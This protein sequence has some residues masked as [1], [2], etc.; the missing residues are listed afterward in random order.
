MPGD[1]SAAPDRNLE[2]NL[3]A[4]AGRDSS[5]AERLRDAREIASGGTLDVRLEEGGRWVIVRRTGGAEQ[6]LTASDQL[7]RNAGRVAEQMAATRLGVFLLLD[8]GLECTR[9]ILAREPTQENE[10]PVPVYL[11][12]P[13]AA[14][15]RAHLQ[16]A[17]LADALEDER[18][19]PFSGPEA[20]G[21]FAKR[22][23][24]RAD[25]P[26]PNRFILHGNLPPEARTG[27]RR[28]IE[29]LDAER[30]RE[31]E[32]LRAELDAYWASEPWREAFA[33]RRPVR[34]LAFRPRRST[35][36]QYSI[37]DLVDAA[38][39]AGIEPR[40][41]EQPSAVS[42]FTDLS[43]LREAA[44]FRP[45]IVL[46]VDHVRSEEKTLPRRVPFLTW[47]QDLTVRLCSRETGR[48]LSERDFV[49]GWGKPM[50]VT[51]YDYP[52]ERFLACGIPTNPDRFGKAPP[53]ARRTFRHD[54]SYVSH[55][56]MHPDE[57]VGRFL[58]AYLRSERNRELLFAFHELLMDP[59]RAPLMRTGPDLHARF[60]AFLEE[61]GA[62]WEASESMR[63]ALLHYWN[64]PY[65]HAYRQIVLGWVADLAEEEGL[66]LGIYGRGWEKLDRFAPYARGEVDNRR[67]LGRLAV[68]SRINLQIGPYCTVHQ[69]LLDGLAAGGFFLHFDSRRLPDL[70]AAVGALAGLCGQNG[71]R[72]PEDFWEALSPEHQTALTRFMA[73]QGVEGEAPWRRRLFAEGLLEMRPVMD[74]AHAFPGVDVER[75][76][77]RDARTLRERCE[78]FSAHPKEV[79]A[80]QEAMRRAT[81]EQH[82][83]AT[84]L[85]RVIAFLE[86]SLMSGQGS[87]RETQGQPPRHEEELES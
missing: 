51:R 5:L 74:F 10:A 53:Y 61:A 78:R 32:R 28:V 34:L 15:L 30:A 72:L 14:L 46:F 4:L 36:V 48:S 67:D 76:F 70:L 44:A 17:D 24:A 43:W 22:L 21:D 38:P 37:Q 11:V 60:D 68:E 59:A 56:S 55:Y 79:Q 42:R 62:E 50:L 81:L 86:R 35:F 58:L 19:V 71:G 6:M 2:R 9:A 23:R 77:F 7:R 12:E 13:D 65:N 84:L 57:A 63:E 64:G 73:E 52:A 82:T 41:A 80:I 75:V 8:P 25:L 29:G 66:D 39:Q 26:I 85:R 87:P 69:R 1:E 16:V 31:A 33:G 40:A 45:D 83:Y 3:G 54:L 20:L 27:V 49:M 47:I 18:L